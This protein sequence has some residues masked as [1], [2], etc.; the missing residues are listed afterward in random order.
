ML[1]TI[2]RQYGAGGSEVAQRIAAALGWSVVDN[3][4]V[5]QV[6]DRAG[7]TTEEVAA[8]DERPPT[9]V[10]RLARTLASSSQ[11]FALP[12]GQL[13]AAVTEPSLVRLTEAVVKEA[14]AHGRVVLV[15][16]AAPAVLGQSV[17]AIHAKMVAAKSFRIQV[18]MERLSLDAKAAERAM[19]EMDARRARYH[20]QY[21]QR[22]WEDPLHYHMVLNTGVLG[23]GGAAELVVA[24][25]RALGW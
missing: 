12:G 19:E 10:E 15:G 22:D 7:L 14:A 11:E 9:F 5:G 16:R 17:G 8:R 1:I 21:Y 13:P 4:I 24:R 23:F 3:E 25:A 2:S 20:K 18:A 6:A